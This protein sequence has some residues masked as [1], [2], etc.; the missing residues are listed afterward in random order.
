MLQDIQRIQPFPVR[1][2]LGLFE[3][4]ITKWDLDIT[5]GNSE[6][7]ALFTKQAGNLVLDF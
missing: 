5:I 7:N 2:T 3:V 4:Y 6:S 1:G